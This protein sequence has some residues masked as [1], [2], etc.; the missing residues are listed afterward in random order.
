MKEEDCIY[1]AD[2]ITDI[3]K[4]REAAVARVRDAVIALCEKYPIYENDIL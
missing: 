4:N 2:L 3:I 1:I